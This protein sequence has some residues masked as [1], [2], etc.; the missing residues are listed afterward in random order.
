MFAKSEVIAVVLEYV[1]GTHMS[2]KV[3]KLR[4]MKTPIL[5]QV[6]AYTSYW[7]VPIFKEMAES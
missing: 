2:T 7:C 4:N 1:F 6:P 3:S 5:W